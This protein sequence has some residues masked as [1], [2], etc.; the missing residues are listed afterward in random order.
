[1]GSVG[2]GAL[3]ATVAFPVLLVWGWVTG[4]LGPKRS[5]AFLIVGV[6]AYFGLPYL[7][8]GRDFVMTAMALI[9]IAL[10]FAVFKGDV[11]VT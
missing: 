1:M 4:E 11:R 6:A 2:I 9:D 10:V 8:N 7:P 5:S 3:I